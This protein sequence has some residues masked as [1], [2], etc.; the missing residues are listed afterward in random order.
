MLL[1]LLSI[2]KKHTNFSN[3]FLYWMELNKNI[4][5]NRNKKVEKNSQLKI[6]VT[7][8]NNLTSFDLMIFVNN[9]Q[10]N[11]WITWL[12]AKALKLLFSG[13]KVNWLIS[14][15]TAIAR[16]VLKIFNNFIR[17]LFLFN[18]STIESNKYKNLQHFCYIC[19]NFQLKTN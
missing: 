9:F 5:L 2:Y 8:L 1:D 17:K 13:P 15:Q 6:R 18:K 19:N 3:Y 12:L 14:L 11:I 10:L 7:K 4:S 16:R